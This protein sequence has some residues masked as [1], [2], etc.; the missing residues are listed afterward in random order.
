MQHINQ[1]AMFCTAS[2]DR[3]LSFALGTVVFCPAWTP[4]FFTGFS[5]KHFQTG[6]YRRRSIWRAKI[7]G[8]NFLFQWNSI[9]SSAGVTQ[10]L[11][12][13]WIFPIPVTN[14]L[15]R[16][17][18][19]IPPTLILNI[20]L[21]NRPI[22]KMKTVLDSPWITILIPVLFINFRVGTNFSDFWP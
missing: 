11:P 17:S 13:R 14:L 1:Y 16:V 8:E 2:S 4:S 19:E 20:F 5:I 22:W 3:Q 7:C 21:T 10:K 12:S 9:L 18:R 15:Y 6:G